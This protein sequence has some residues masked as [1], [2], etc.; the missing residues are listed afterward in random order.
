MP[1]K[2]PPMFMWLPPSW[3]SL[4]DLVRHHRPGEQDY[5][6]D[7][8]RQT[9]PVATD[10]NRATKPSAKS[11]DRTSTC[12][13]SDPSARCRFVAPLRPEIPHADD[14]DCA[15]PGADGSGPIA[16]RGR[17]TFPALSYGLS[18]QL[19]DLYRIFPIAGS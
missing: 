12:G 1:V 8:P 6:G 5:H 13:L 16:E 15:R 2:K 14:S 18:R 10:A 9:E 7:P 17:A 4:A 19:P 11:T 3:K